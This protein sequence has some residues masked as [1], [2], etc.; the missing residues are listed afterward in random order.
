MS[1]LSFA[2]ETVSILRPTLKEEW[3]QEVLDW[4]ET[5]EHE[6]EGCVTYGLS[7]METVQ[8]IDV[9]AGTRVVFMPADADIQATDLVRWNEQDWMIM[10]EPVHQTSPIG[11]VDHVAVTL[12]HWE[13]K[14]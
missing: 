4:S 11:T 3:G 12:K 5:A 13:G 9:V 7:G 8:G 6:V 2:T 10:G 14:K 1:F